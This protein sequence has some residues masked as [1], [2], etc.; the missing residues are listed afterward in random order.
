[1]RKQL[2]FEQETCYSEVII[3][4]CVCVS[5]LARVVEGPIE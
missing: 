3:R 1:M 2:I 4:S 5:W